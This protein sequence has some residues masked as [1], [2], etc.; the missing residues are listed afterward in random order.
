VG[1]LFR[2]AKEAGV[3]GRNEVRGS[4]VQ[5]LLIGE[6]ARLCTGPERVAAR[7]IVRDRDR[8]DVGAQVEQASRLAQIESVESLVEPLI[9]R[10]DEIA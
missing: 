2:S 5:R 10:E 8:S 3:F 1:F 4:G 9:D 6:A 7:R